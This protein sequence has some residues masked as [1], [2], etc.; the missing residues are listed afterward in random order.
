MKHW[1][2]TGLMGMLVALTTVRA[3]EAFSKAIRP[4]DFAAAELE[5]LFHD[6]AARAA[7]I[8]AMNEFG[9]RLGEEDASPSQRAARVLLDFIK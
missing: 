1:L 8:E 5:K 2:A 7:Q 3:E 6:P 4:E 9:R